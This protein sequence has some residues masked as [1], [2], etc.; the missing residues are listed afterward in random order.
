[1]TKTNRTPEVTALM[2]RNLTRELE[3]A[4]ETANRTDRKTDHLRVR[5]IREEMQDVRLGR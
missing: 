2:L 3:A 4:I 5:A 1:M